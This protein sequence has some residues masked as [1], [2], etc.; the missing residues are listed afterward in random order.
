M[1]GGVAK[2]SENL[3][4]AITNITKNTKI[5]TQYLVFNGGH[6]HITIRRTSSLAQAVTLLA[7]I[8]GG[9]RPP[10]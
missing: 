3:M 7:C 4:V 2:V 1:T 5:I 10:G 6:A 9:D 8:Q